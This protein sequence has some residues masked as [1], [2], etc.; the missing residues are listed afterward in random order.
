MQKDL[1]AA[2]TLTANMRRKKSNT[3]TPSA[4]HND[5]EII[6]KKDKAGLS[7]VLEMVNSLKVSTKLS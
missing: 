6:V 3:D 2:E 5:E 7:D 4:T 1:D